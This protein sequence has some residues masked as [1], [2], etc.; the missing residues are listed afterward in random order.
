MNIAPRQIDEILEAHPAVLEAASVGV[1]DRYVGEDLVAFAVLLPGMRCAE[2]ELLRF[3]KAIWAFSKR[4]RACISSP[5]CRKALQAKYS[6]C[7]WR[8]RRKD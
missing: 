7:A 2:L 8:S 3:A 1:P 4:R 6:G 5:I